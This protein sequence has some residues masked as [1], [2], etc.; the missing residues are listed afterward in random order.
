MWIKAIQKLGIYLP[1]TYQY[2]PIFTDIS[3]YYVPPLKRSV[4]L[5]QITVSFLKS[6]TQNELRD[7]IYFSVPFKQLSKSV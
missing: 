1:E 2:F 5:S 4:M 7:F 6:L 3:T